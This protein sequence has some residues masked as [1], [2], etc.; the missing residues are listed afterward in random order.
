LDDQDD[1][2]YSRAPE[3]EDLLS[4]CIDLL[5]DASVEN[6]QSLKRA[7]SGLPTTPSRW[8]LTTKSRNTGL[9]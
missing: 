6:V 5:V 8:S 1:R 9:S 7:V 3:L 4:L 2:G